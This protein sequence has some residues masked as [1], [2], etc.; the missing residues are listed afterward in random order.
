MT[1][2]TRNN[3]SSDFKTKVALEAIQGVKTLNEIGQEF[4][5][6]MDFERHKFFC[7]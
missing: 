4:V 3:F 7:L 2:R 6:Q 5:V 1:K